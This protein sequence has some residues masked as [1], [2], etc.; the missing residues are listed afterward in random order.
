[1]FMQQRFPE[2]ALHEE[3]LELSFQDL[4]IILSD[5]NLN[6]RGEEQVYEAGLTWISITW[7]IGNS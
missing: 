7:L 1:M 4:C 2:I 5:G 6:V 3:F